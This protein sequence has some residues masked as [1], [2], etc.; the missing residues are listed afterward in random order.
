MMKQVPGCL[1]VGERSFG[2]SGNP[3]PIALGNG[4][5]VYLPCWKDL[6]L[7]GTCF[8]GEGIAPD[9]EVKTT[10]GDFAARDP[11]AEAAL[12]MLRMRQ[13]RTRD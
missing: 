8:E 13:T 5:T 9:I 4:V 12:K 3:Q 6:R 11:V 2:A 7:D 10:M 1:L